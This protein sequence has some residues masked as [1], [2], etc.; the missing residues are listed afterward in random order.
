MVIIAYG[1]FRICQNKR[2]GC[3]TKR[4]DWTQFMR[5]LLHRSKHRLRSHQSQGATWSPS[6]ITN[7]PVPLHQKSR[8]QATRTKILAIV[9]RTE[10]SMVYVLRN[11]KRLE[12]IA[13]LQGHKR[14]SEAAS[15]CDSATCCS[16]LSAQIA[17]VH[18]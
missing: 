9:A 11:T 14:A 6:M 15:I 16:L 8:T 12:K 3:P 10:I 7:R 18:A 1:L 13:G 2:N 17:H 4:T 5:N